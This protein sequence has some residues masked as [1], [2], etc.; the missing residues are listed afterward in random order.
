MKLSVIF[1]EEPHGWGSRGN[2]GFWEYLKKRASDIEMPLSDDTLEAWIKE[3]HL[4]LTG[5][6]LTSESDVYIKE[7]DQGGMSAGRVFGA[8]WIEEGIP[9]LKERLKYYAW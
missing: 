8:W 5:V 1:E 2:P 4:K 6:E 9:L 3:E 7:F